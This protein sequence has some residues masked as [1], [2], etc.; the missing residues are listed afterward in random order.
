MR[1]KYTNI[2][3]TLRISLNICLPFN[4]IFLRGIQS[5]V[6]L[7]VNINVSITVY[8]HVFVHLL[9]TRIFITCSVFV[10]FFIVFFSIII[11]IIFFCFAKK[12]LSHDFW[13]KCCK[14]KLCLQFI[15]FCV[16]VTTIVYLNTNLIC[17]FG[18]AIELNLHYLYE[19]R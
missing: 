17:K 15:D 18:E 3:L 2:F 8:I 7:H 10:N 6:I 9:H 4:C 19:V 14:N 13:S 1:Y 12:N 5:V 16:C 11:I